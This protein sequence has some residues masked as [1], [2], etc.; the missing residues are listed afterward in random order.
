MARI[1]EQLTGPA[2]RSDAGDRVVLRSAVAAVVLW[3]LLA[4]A[5]LSQLGPA[6]AVAPAV[7][8]VAVTR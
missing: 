1:L 3:L 4:L 8:V 6:R 2:A 5:W 7:L